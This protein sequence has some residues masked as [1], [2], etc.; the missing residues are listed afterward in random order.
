M[1]KPIQEMTDEEI[2]ELVTE[3]LPELTDLIGYT[4]ILTSRLSNGDLRNRITSTLA[5][6]L[7]L[8]QFLIDNANS[9]I[10]VWKLEHDFDDTQP[11]SD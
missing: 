11:E 6:D 1:N 8:S 4:L 7:D 2:T 9:L 10:E 3:R 5:T